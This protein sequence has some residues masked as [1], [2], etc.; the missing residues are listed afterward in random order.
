MLNELAKF[1]DGQTSVPNNAAH[2]KGLDGIVPGNRDESVVVAHGNVLAL[3]NYSKAR[4][5]QS[6]Y[7][8]KVVDACKFRHVTPSLPLR[9]H[10]PRAITRPAPPGTLR[11]RP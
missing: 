10:S 3:T 8:A 2:R 9:E 5:F 11:S 7:C 4:F 6:R 1:F